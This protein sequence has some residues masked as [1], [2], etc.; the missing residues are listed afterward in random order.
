MGGMIAI[1]LRER[2]DAGHGGMRWLKSEGGGR[3]L[4]MRREKA[5][6][7]T[8]E[9]DGSKTENVAEVSGK[10]K[11]WFR[12]V[13]FFYQRAFK[14]AASKEEQR[15]QADEHSAHRRRWRAGWWEIF[16]RAHTPG[17]SDTTL[18][19]ST[20]TLSSRQE[21]IVNPLVLIRRRAVPANASGLQQRRRTQRRSHPYNSQGQW[22]SSRNYTQNLIPQ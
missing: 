11:S 14:I 16:S 9:R 2:N 17:R 21:C 7:V 5:V 18:T 6:G 20:M 15:L 12:D 19:P 1:G 3:S 13:F 8:E 4:K 22:G 10:E